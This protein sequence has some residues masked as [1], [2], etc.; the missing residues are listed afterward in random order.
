MSS[1][2]ETWA[3]RAQVMLVPITLIAVAI[4]FYQTQSEL[5]QTREANVT[6]QAGPRRSLVMSG[7]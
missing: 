2:A 6:Y 5:K 1:T 7:W 4:T 3:H